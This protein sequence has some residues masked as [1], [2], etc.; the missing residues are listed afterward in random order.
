MDGYYEHI[1]CALVHTRVTA[2]SH[3]VPH[4]KPTPCASCLL[5]PHA[6]FH[7]PGKPVACTEHASSCLKGSWACMAAAMHAA[8]GVQYWYY[9]L[10]RPLHEPPWTSYTAGQ[11]A[12]KVSRALLLLM[13]LPQ[14]ARWR[15]VRTGNSFAPLCLL[16]GHGEA[17]RE[18]ARERE[19]DF[20]W[21][22]ALVPDAHPA[23]QL[24][25]EVAEGA[26][27]HPACKAMPMHVMLLAA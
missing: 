2:P 7:R 15:R 6:R 24:A 27:C 3:P 23:V 26:S 8:S 11:P 20:T 22:M 5:V 21:T 16:W 14:H 10:P 18:R 1:I 17:E 12:C 25:L 4:L 19:R 13:S 9:V